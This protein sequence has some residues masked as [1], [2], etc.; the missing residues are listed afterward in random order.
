[1]EKSYKVTHKLY[2]NDRLNKVLFHGKPTYPLYVQVT[3]DR[4]TIVFKS[5]LFE[6]LSKP[7]YG[8]SQLGEIY[9]PELKDIIAKEDALIDFVIEKN[10]EN[11]SLDTFKKDYNYFSRD[12]LDEMENGFREFLYAFFQDEGMPWLAISLSHGSKSI[13]PFNIVLDLKIALNKKTYDKLVVNSCYYAPPYYLLYNFALK[14]HKE[15]PILLSVSDWVLVGAKEKFQDFLY[16]NYPEI[17]SVDI[18]KQVQSFISNL[19]A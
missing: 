4:K 1:M 8:L 19:Y 13:S 3:F 6:L 15:N 11:F 17:N 14:W 12:L 5:N 10:L 7:K 2:Y 9:E 18:L 16:T